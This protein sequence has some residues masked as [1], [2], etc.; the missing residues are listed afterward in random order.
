[1]YLVL[2]PG[3]GSLARYHIALLQPLGCNDFFSLIFGAVR[4]TVLSLPHALDLHWLHRMTS[5]LFQALH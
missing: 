1:M 3:S 5:M 2:F 4:Y